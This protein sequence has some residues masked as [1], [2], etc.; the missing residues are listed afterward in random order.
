MNEKI[1]VE[2]M[3]CVSKNLEFDIKPKKIKNL[4]NKNLNDPICI[5]G[6]PGVADIGKIALD[7]LTKA[8]NAEK[9]M[10]ITFT[11]YPAGA[12]INE[13]LLYAPT[14]EVYFYKDP[15]NQ[16]DLFL[17][18]ADA[19]PMSPRGIYAISEFF[20]RLMAFYKVS[21]ILTL[22]GYPIERPNREINVYVTATSDQLLEDFTKNARVQKIVKGV[23]VGP[24][25][26]VP[27]LAKRNYNI[28][29]LVLLAETNGYAAMNGD[30]YDLKASL[31]LIEL[32]NQELYLAM[33]SEYT[34]EQ[35]ARMEIKLNNEKENIK[36]E[37]GIKAESNKTSLG[38][39]C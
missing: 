28:D 12:I 7:H 5:L 31:A 36:Q 9:I 21:L 38:Y 17:V 24:N 1:P 33:D 23:V 29:G 39:I 15:K 10:D 22:G 27:T 2:K 34:H 16:H 25:G 14:A 18:T 13:S 26:L 11:D 35:I 6:F 3:E 4:D 32:I 30:S 20:A 19:Q 37:L 8:L